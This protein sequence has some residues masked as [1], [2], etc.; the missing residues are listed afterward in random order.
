MLGKFYGL[1]A[2][3]FLVLANHCFVREYDALH[4]L[5]SAVRVSGK[6]NSDEWGALIRV[7][8]VAE[9]RR[10]LFHLGFDLIG[11]LRAF[12]VY[13]RTRRVQG[14]S[15]VTQQLVRTLTLDFRPVLGRKIKEICLAVK[16]ETH[17][18]KEEI[19][20]KYISCAYFG[21][22]AKGVDQAISRF[23]LRRPIFITSSVALI[24]RLRRPQ[25]AALSESYM[26]KLHLRI[27]SIARMIE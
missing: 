5:Y 24:A 12:W 4:K 7:L 14:A 3:P 15:T 19:A 8:I 22:G 16:L 20:K 10:Y 13:L 6:I 9:D 26:L 23:S 2:L 21:A 25:P 11:V 17:F 1:A 27:N 18:S